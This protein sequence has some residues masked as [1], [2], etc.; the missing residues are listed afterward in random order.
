M[1]RTKWSSTLL[2]TL[3]LCTA[4]LVQADDGHAG[5]QHKHG[6]TK[7]TTGPHGGAVSV[8]DGYYCEVVFQPKSVRV[9][10]FD[11]QGKP[12]ATKGVRGSVTM[13]VTGNPKQYRYNLYPKATEDAEQNS[14]SLSIDLSRIRDGGMTASF[15]LQGVS[16]AGQPIAFTQTFRLTADAEQSAIAQQRICPV[17]G[18]KLG[19]MGRPIQTIVNGRAVFVC[20]KGCIGRLQ[21][22]P[23]RYLARLPYPAPAQA[24]KEDAAAIT[25]QGMCPV[26]EEPLRSMGVPWKVTVKGQSVFVCCKG[27]IKKVQ[28]R[29][30]FYI[31]KVTELTRAIRKPQQ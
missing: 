21:R 12:L 6:E 16:R 9:Y 17:S 5:H 25:R 29:P 8:V 28:Q 23:G 11:S 30:D 14:L 4:R 20:C 27:C 10:L 15:A 24:T 1:K 3:A 18:K 2:L 19:S 22:D 26:M 13:K 7:P 31:A